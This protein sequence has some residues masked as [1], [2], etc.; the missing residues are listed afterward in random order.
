M[1]TAIMPILF[2][3]FLVILGYYNTKGY[4][5]SIHW[6]HRTHVREEDK[7]P[8]GRL[9]GFGTGIIG[10]CFIIFGCSSFLTEKT[11]NKLF[12]LIGGILIIL[13]CIIG[14]SIS[15]YAMLKYNKGIFRFK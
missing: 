6:Y 2:G 13:G 8:F 4:I 11:Q 14:L 12:L 3:I 9:I 10:I 7:L 5:S 1:E 15:V